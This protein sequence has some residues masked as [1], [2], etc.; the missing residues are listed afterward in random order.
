[1]YVWIGTPPIVDD[2]AKRLHVFETVADTTGAYTIPS[3]GPK[4]LP[5]QARVSR[6][7]PHLRVFK[8]GYRPHSVR[9]KSA[10]R[11]H[12]AP[13]SDWDGKVLELER[14]HEDLREQASRLSGLY[15]GLTG[16]PTFIE[17]WEAENDWKNYPYATLEVI[18]ELERLDALGMNPNYGAI[19]PRMKLFTKEDQKFLRSLE[20]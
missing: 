7:S 4:L 15:D 19:L 3:W 11:K 1:M 14:P 12:G 18:C 2:R 20:K 6:A 9:N 17:N 5:P 16:G 13:E 10:G 8:R